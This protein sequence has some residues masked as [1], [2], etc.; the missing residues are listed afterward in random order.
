MSNAVGRRYAKALFELSMESKS[1]DKVSK[2]LE[3]LMAQM[4]ASSD[5]KDFV[6]SPLYA[7]EQ[8]L[9]FINEFAKKSKLEKTVANTLA[10]MAKNGRLDS[11][12]EMAQAYKDMVAAQN[13]EIVAD[14]TSAKELT[15]A[16]KKNLASVL[17]SKVGKDV[18]INTHVDPD[19]LGG[20][21]VNIGST[22]IDNSLKGKLSKLHNAMKEVG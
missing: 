3:E 17:K 22:M 18:A 8:K 7:R 1:I 12:P 6:S 11:I 14:V 5:M 13:D 2:S 9:A 16:Q 4:E 19:I 20:L 21:I 15:A 10:V